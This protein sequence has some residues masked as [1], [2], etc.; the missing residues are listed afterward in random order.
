MILNTPINK[1]GMRT[2]PHNI[3]AEQSLLGA[4]L[5]SNEYYESVCEIVLPIHFAAPVNGKVY[6]AIGSLISR[7][8]IADPITLRA[9]FE[10]NDELKNI[11]GG[12]YLI[13]LV[14]SVV[15][16]SGVEDYA[17]VIRDMYLRRQLMLL[18]DDV[19]RKA[20]TFDL[21]VDVLNQVEEAEVRLYELS[22]ADNRSGPELF[23][24]ALVS[25]MGMLELAFN[26]KS[27]IN[28]I[29]TGFLDLDT[30][31][32]G[33]SRSD[34]IILAGRPSMGKTA[35][36][37]NIAF[38]AAMAHCTK[39][40]GGGKAL[41][42]SLEMSKEQLVTRIL[43]QQ[44]KIP[45]EKIRRGDL[46]GD[47]FT[48]LLEAGRNIADLPLYID[49]TPALTV[50][51]LKSRARKLQRQYGVDLIVVDYLQLLHGNGDKKNENRVQEIAE[52]TRTLKAIAKE[53]N[54]PVLALSQLSRAVESREDK[55]PQLSDLRESGSIEQDA[56]VVAFVYREEYYESRREPSDPE[57]HKKWRVKMAALTG[58]AEVIVAKQRHGPI[59]TV[60]MFFDG[61]YTKFDNL[62]ESRGQNFEKKVTE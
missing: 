42:F 35:L 30:K 31:L 43:S 21:N 1:T 13:Q 23:S 2:L 58:L 11:G 54:V 18:A 51:S 19:S 14:N 56:D 57:E 24:K 12:T 49:D 61:R 6:E 39:D 3:E 29:T 55:R 52:I 22:T 37:T 17:K 28:G 33:L 59:G 15:S 25:T 7:G 45:S 40:D 10:K 47:E 5:I 16:I 44:S 50:S 27:K 62:A 38:N 26:N 53:L 20:S 4:I 34:L 46:R 60:K 32:G 41:F 8:L 36:A 9:Y 48:K